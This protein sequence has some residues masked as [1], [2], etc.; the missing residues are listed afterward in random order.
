MDLLK[1]EKSVGVHFR[2]ENEVWIFCSYK[3]ML[4]Y[5]FGVGRRE[6]KDFLG[7]KKNIG[8][9]F[10]ELIRKFGVDFWG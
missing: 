8:V 1:L 2:T 3:G 6:R 4:E 5:I 9:N 10:L 7:L